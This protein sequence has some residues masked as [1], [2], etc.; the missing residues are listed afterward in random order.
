MTLHALLAREFPVWWYAVVLL[1][2]T[3][4]VAAARKIDWRRKP[5]VTRLLRAAFVVAPFAYLGV[6]LL[7]RSYQGT[8]AWLVEWLVVLSASVE[9]YF[10]ALIELKRDG[11]GRR[12]KLQRLASVLRAAQ[13]RRGA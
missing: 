8:G 4:S 5:P 7:L 11:D 9:L 2:C 6:D 13:A 10:G 3:L 1:S 12:E